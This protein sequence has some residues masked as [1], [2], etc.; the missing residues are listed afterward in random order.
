MHDRR[1]LYL[2][3]GRHV[4]RRADPTAVR[5]DPR[6]LVGRQ[7]GGGGHAF[8]HSGHLA[9]VQRASDPA[10]AE[11]GTEQGAVE[12]PGLVKPR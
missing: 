6:H 3:A 8:Q 4:L 12:D 2:V 11:H 1:Q 7:A 9:G 5:R 10:P